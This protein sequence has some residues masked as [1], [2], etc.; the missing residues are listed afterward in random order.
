MLENEMKKKVTKLKKFEI[1]APC[2]D[3]FLEKTQF[4]I[5]EN[6]NK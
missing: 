1:H 5:R 4:E 2:F 3:F 6:E